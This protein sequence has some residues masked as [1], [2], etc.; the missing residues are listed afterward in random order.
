M[1]LNWPSKIH[2]CIGHMNSIIF[3]FGLRNVEYVP[4]FASELRDLSQVERA[5]RTGR[6]KSH[7]G[8]ILGRV[9]TRHI[10]YTVDIQL[11]TPRPDFLVPQSSKQHF[12]FLVNVHKLCFDLS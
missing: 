7:G 1:L 11:C 10:P 9:M 6:L 4:Y 5:I 8:N 2:T 12:I 3:L